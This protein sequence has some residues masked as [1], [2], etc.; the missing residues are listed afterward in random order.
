MKTRQLIDML[1]R[2]AGPA[3]RRLVERRL[4]AAVA[5][6]ALGSVL[7]VAAV[8]GFNPALGDM[9]AVLLMKAA[10][11]AGLLAGASWLAARLARPGAPWRAALAGLAAVVGAM[12]ALAA[13]VAARAPADARPELLLGHS[14]TSCPW[15]VALLSAPALVAA[16]WAL[17]GLAPTRPG[18]AGFA[19]GLLSGSLGALGYALY[20]PETS[21]LFVLVWYTLGMLIPA[22]AGALAGP[23][24]LRW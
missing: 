21:P 1:S 8:Y 18:W 23:A 17:R 15:S 12:A 24:L 10:Y 5:A 2:Q 11:A 9:G 14:W 13:A 19:A 20:C 6:G 7:A 3:P 4:G 22:F 16:M